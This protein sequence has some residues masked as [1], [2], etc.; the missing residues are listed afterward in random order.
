MRIIGILVG[1]LAVMVML[2]V[3]YFWAALSWNYS[4]GERAG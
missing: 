4:T 2:V 3:G 1:I